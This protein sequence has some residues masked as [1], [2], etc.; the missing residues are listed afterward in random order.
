VVVLYDR[1]VLEQSLGRKV[2]VLYADG[3]TLSCCYRGEEVKK[4]QVVVLALECVLP[5]TDSACTI[6]V[7]C[8]FYKEPLK[9]QKV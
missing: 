3:S 5:R 8:A 9:G 1:D 4:Q 2:G 6:L 7:S